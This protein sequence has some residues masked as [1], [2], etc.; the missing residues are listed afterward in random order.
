MTSEKSW[1]V[2][3]CMIGKGIRA[4]QNAFS[5]RRSITIESFPPE[6]RR[7]GCSN[8]AATSRMMKMDSSSS[9]SRCVRSRVTVIDTSGGIR[10][11]LDGGHGGQDVRGDLGSGDH[12]VGQPGL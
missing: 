5:A 12:E 1:P 6:K 7:T 3:T 2:S 8:S 4:G 10:F 9:S 11:D